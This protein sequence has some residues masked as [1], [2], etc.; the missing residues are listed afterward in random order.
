MTVSNQHQKKTQHS[1]SLPAQ[2]ETEL[3]LVLAGPVL[4]RCDAQSVTVW[5]VTTSRLEGQFELFHAK[6]ENAFFQAELTAEQQIQVGRSAWIVMAQ[7]QGE[8]PVDCELAYEIQ[9]Q[10]GP[11]STLIPELLYP[12]EKRL[13]LMIKSRA[14]YIQHGSCRNP[15]FPGKDSLVAADSKVAALAVSE[16]P[17][18][19][20]MSGDQIYADHVAGPTLDAIS[21][22]IDLLGL[23]DEHFSDAPYASLSELRHSDY[24][25]YGRDQVLPVHE[26]TGHWLSDSRGFS[27]LPKRCRPVFSSTDCENHLIGLSEFLAMYLLVWSPQVWRLVDHGR[28]AQE[29]FQCGTQVLAEKWQ[30]LWHRE[31]TEIDGFI[32]GLNQVQRL[33]AH[34]PT[35]MIFDDHDVTDDW[36][37]TVGWEQAVYQN[38]FS[39]RIIG[40][41]LFGYWLCQ[42]WGNDPS[43]FDER[44]AAKARAFFSQPSDENHEAMISLLYEF[45]HWHYEIATQPKILVLD[46]RTRR[47]RSES[48][49]NKP[50]GLM[51]WE[52]LTEMQQ[53]LM[54]E[55]AVIIV[56]P[57]PIF[58]VKF[59]EALQRIMTWLGKPLMVDAENW[60]AHP[61]AANTLLSIFTHTKTPTNFVILSGDVHYSFA[62]DIKLRFRRNS[63]H[64]YQVT[65]SGIKNTFPERLLRFCERMD[66]LLYTPSSPLNWLT[67]RKRM[68]IEK[69]DPDTPG[70]GRLVNTSCIGELW[71]HESGRPERIAILT[72][73]GETIGFPPTRQESKRLA[74]TEKKLN[75]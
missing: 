9:T 32:S 70:H 69:R 73:E 26:E 43:R 48:K 18:L 17:A 41:S 58:G 67:K 37:L 30:Q 2:D 20:M 34:I 45:E 3:P 4:R 11:V 16:R 57:A 28:L 25:L 12:G 7:F 36:N 38:A 65:A 8:F 62:Y 61:G 15:H 72:A 75:S 24:Q 14:D 60:M 47:W 6:E 46:T 39:R 22:V 51:D 13:S 42:G 40:N 53:A 56:S 54:H 31:M 64:I 50:S 33:M 5:M 29:G 49:M 71:I 52:A 74:K 1:S 44:F 63:P 19:L 66:R 10:Q 35:Y 21:Q 27:W 23:P 68:K 59:I 55:S